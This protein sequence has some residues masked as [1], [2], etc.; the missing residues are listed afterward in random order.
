M[1]MTD[2]FDNGL[3]LNDRKRTEF[4][5]SD[6]DVASAFAHATWSPLD[7]AYLCPHCGVPMK[8]MAMEFAYE[9]GRFCPLNPWRVANDARPESGA[10][11]FEMA[12]VREGKMSLNGVRK[13]LIAEAK[14][15]VTLHMMTW[16]GEKHPDYLKAVVVGWR[17]ID[18]VTAR[19]PAY[20]CGMPKVVIGVQR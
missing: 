2:P 9:H 14:P 3:A 15:R 17:E 13:R 7:K 10:T 5:V 16:V 18:Q 12:L 19:W 1:S 4:P 8:G 11:A 6:A 20:R